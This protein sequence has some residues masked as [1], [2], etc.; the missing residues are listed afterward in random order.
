[1]AASQ[2]CGYPL[3]RIFNMGDTP[4]QFKMPPNHILK[5]SGS[6]TVPMKSCSAEKRSFTVTLAVAADGKKLP[7]KVTFKGI[8]TLRDLVVSNSVCV[9]LH[10]KGW[11]DEANKLAVLCCSFALLIYCFKALLMSLSDG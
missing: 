9:S 2:Y 5:F 7:P 3:P 6:L 8:Q 4:M 11:R 1:M 10:K